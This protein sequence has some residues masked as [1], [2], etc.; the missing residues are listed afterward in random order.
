MSPHETNVRDLYEQ[1]LLAWNRR[2]AVA[3][4]G[5][6]EDDGSIVGFDGSQ[7]DSRRAIEEHLRPI[8]ASHPTAAYVARVREIRMLSPDV[9]LLRAVAGM[10]PPGG[11]DLNPAVN[12]IH[13]LIGRRNNGEW[14][15]A[16]FQSTPAAWHGRPDDAA[17]LLDE[18]RDVSRRGMTVM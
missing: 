14:R 13:T 8:F 15:A 2:D 7:A 4:A 16:M 3:M 5:Q 9:A 12:T 10:I 6:F 17:A 1:I 18:L 11:G